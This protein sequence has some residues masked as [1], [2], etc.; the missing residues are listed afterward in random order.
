M[1]NKAL[2]EIGAR[3]LKQTVTDIG[4]L[5]KKEI[6]DLEIYVRKGILEKGQGGPYPKLKNVYA[7]KGF[8]FQSHRIES[9][10]RLRKQM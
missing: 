2:P 6:Q 7:L 8:D 10:E 3:A 5:T 4:Q 1:N 9:I